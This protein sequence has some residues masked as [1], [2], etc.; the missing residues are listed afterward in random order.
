[1]FSGCNVTGERTFQSLNADFL[2]KVTVER[3][4]ESTFESTFENLN[5]DFRV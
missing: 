1:M 4:F 5:A 3:T 2:C